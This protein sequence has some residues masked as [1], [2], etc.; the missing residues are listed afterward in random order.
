MQ[1][2]LLL[3]SRAELGEGPAWD[4]RSGRLY[5]VD[6]H[7]GRLHVFDPKEKSDRSLDAP[8]RARPADWCSACRAASPASTW[9]PKF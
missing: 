3:D 2:E 5:W 9:K 8:S 4:E 1:P 7:A 6:I